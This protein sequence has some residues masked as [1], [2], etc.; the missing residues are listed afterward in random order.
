MRTM[1]GTP[2]QGLYGH[3]VRRF[4]YDSGRLEQL[5]TFSEDRG[6]HCMI[7]NAQAFTD[8]ISRKVV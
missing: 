8:V 7:I 5:T 6:L 1:Q 4:I 2:F 3:K